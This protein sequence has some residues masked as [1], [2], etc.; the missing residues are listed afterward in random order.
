VNVFVEG[1][2]DET[3]YVEGMLRWGCAPPA[4]RISMLAKRKEPSG[5]PHVERALIVCRNIET[6]GGVGGDGTSNLSRLVDSTLPMSPPHARSLHLTPAFSSHTS[7]HPPLLLFRNL[8]CP[9]LLLVGPRPSLPHLLLVRPRHS[10]PHA[11][12]LP[13]SAFPP[14]RSQDPLLVTVEN[15]GSPPFLA[16]GLRTCSWSR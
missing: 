6:E 12:E 13:L 7:H 14:C 1:E 3:F 16:V 5:F 10:L 4:P 15:L 11:T 2:V 9:H 8:S